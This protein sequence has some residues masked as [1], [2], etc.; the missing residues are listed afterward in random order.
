M[1]S[2]LLPAIAASA[3]GI[4]AG[5][6]NLITGVMV[7][8][9]GKKLSK[10]STDKWKEK[11]GMPEYSTP[12]SFKDYQ[13]LMRLR[14]R[15]EMPG[16][17]EAKQAIEETTATGLGQLGQLGS[18]SD[19]MAGLLG[20]MGDRRRAL[21]QLGLSAMQYQDRAKRDYIGSVGQGAQYE[22][23]AWEMNEYNPWQIK[24]N[25][26]QGYQNAAMGMM[27]GG[28]EQM[29]GATTEGANLWAQ[30]DWFNRMNPQGQGG[31]QPPQG[32]MNPAWNPSV[33]PGY[34]QQQGFNQVGM[35]QPPWVPPGQHISYGD[36]I[37]PEGSSYKGLDPGDYSKLR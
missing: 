28:F 21:R 33:P 14:S 25:L 7:G 26:Q 29:M 30:Q 34:Y 11:V 6:A 12:E 35:T 27:S 9:Q 24:Q 3:S 2:S 32:G 13:E 8:K 18:G 36:W 37:P 23:R 22:D 4:G 5:L 10:M 1:A 15:Q 20:L 17:G 31:Q 16:Y 19:R